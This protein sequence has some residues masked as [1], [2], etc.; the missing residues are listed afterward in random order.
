M[1]KILGVEQDGMF[2]PKTQAAYKEAIYVHSRKVALEK[3]EN[4]I[5]CDKKYSKKT[6]PKSVEKPVRGFTNLNA[7]ISNEKNAVLD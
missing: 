5:E 2:G 6:N 1:Q 7:E 4:C 3:P